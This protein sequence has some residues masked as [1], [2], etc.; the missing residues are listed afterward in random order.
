WAGNPRA[1]DRRID[2]FALGVIVFRAL[3]SRMPSPKAGLI[4][5][6]E[7]A[8][9]GERPSLYALRP[10]LPRSI[11]VWLEKALAVEPEERFQ[12]V[13]ALWN[14]LEAMLATPADSPY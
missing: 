6:M 3:T 9:R 2:V 12:S 4:G 10:G 14:A 5:T 1:L 13:R 11:D 8:K 7:W